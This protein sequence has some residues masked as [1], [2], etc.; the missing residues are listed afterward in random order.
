MQFLKRKIGQRQGK[1]V[2]RGPCDLGGPGGPGGQ[3]NLGEPGGHGGPGDLHSLVRLVQVIRVVRSLQDFEAK[4]AATVSFSGVADIKLSGGE[5]VV[6]V[7]HCDSAGEHF[8]CVTIP[9]PRGP[10]LFFF[11]PRRAVD[12][13]LPGTSR[14]Q[15]VIALRDLLFPGRNITT[16]KMLKRSSTCRVARRVGSSQ[17]TPFSAL[18]QT[19]LLSFERVLFFSFP[20]GI[21][22]YLER[23]SPKNLH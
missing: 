5:H 16:T 12:G 23:E 10:F 11:L 4:A 22:L 3:C 9:D 18:L 1:G 17:Q 6:Q 13:I 7:D 20:V 8:D 15:S 19:K 21:F 2:S 14:Q